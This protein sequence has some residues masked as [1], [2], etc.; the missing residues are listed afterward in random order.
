LGA[1]IQV[2]ALDFDRYDGFM[3]YLSLGLDRK[4]G[5]VISLGLGYTFYGLRLEAKDEDLRG[6][7]RMRHYGPK[8]YLSFLF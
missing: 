7:F 4:F 8:L 5:D 1:D 6:T 3:S 2:F